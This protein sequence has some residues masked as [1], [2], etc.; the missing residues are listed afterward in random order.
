MLESFV[1][2]LAGPVAV[3]R[4]AALGRAHAA[5]D[6]PL[7][8]VEHRAGSARLRCSESHD[9]ARE[10]CLRRQAWLLHVVAAAGG[11]RA[12][13]REDSCIC[14]GEPACEYVVS[15]TAQP[16][17]TPV[18]AAS[19]IVALGL[20]AAL[21]HASRPS[22]AWALVPAVAVATYAVERRR[23]ARSAPAS[24]AESGAAFR[25]LLGQVVAA[26]AESKAPVAPRSDEHPEP[27]QARHPDL[28]VM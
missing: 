22:A 23:C 17:L 19:A 16:R 14:A 13:V 25:W 24:S 26:R 15:W 6:G 27:V 3:Y 1:A 5:R 8:L 18:T 10:R 7:V 9:D 21:P 28:P 2:R 12:T 20:L 4:L 11:T